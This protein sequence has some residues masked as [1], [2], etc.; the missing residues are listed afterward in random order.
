VLLVLIFYR[1]KKNIFLILNIH[2]ALAEKE[3]AREDLHGRADMQ[4]KRAEHL[5][6]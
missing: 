3:K 4:E 2:T 5:N 6:E 1:L